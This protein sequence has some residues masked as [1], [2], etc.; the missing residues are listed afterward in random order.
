M[1]L[2]QKHEIRRSVLLLWLVCCMMVPLSSSAEMLDSI[3]IQRADGMAVIKITLTHNIRYKRHFPQDRGSIVNIYFDDVSLENTDRPKLTPIQPGSATPDTGTHD[4]QRDE[5]LRS[6]PSDLMPF[7]WV[8]HLR[9]E[10]GDSS[11]EPFYIQV[12]FSEV[13]NFSLRADEENRAFYIY[14]PIAQH[15]NQR[16]RSP[17][18]A[19]V[20]GGGGAVPVIPSPP[21]EPTP[22]TAPASLPTPKSEPATGGPP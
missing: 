13:V 7:F 6:P 15:Q 20:K 8:A 9:N 21:A 11:F 16:N 19:P 12:Q 17:S 4:T 1:M 14:V 2:N 3:D 5:Y 18:P 22:A 10:S